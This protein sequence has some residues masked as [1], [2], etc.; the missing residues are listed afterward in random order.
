MANPAYEQSVD[1]SCPHDGWYNG[2]P[3]LMIINGTYADYRPR[4][5]GWVASG[6]MKASDL[7]L[8][9][10][11][12]SEI[13]LSEK[14]K[15]RN[16]VIEDTTPKPVKLRDGKIEMQAK[17]SDNGLRLAD[18]Q[19]QLRKPLR[20]KMAPGSIANRP[21][22]LALEAMS[23]SSRAMGAEAAPNGLGKTVPQFVPQASQ[24]PTTN[25][26]K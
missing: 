15:R 8:F 13:Q 22:P 3:K 2:N 11:Q 23:A 16:K 19:P 18:G 26:P 9:D 5:E 10:K 1:T 17:P 25:L 20:A 14:Q 12:W 4:L 21:D 7:A 24:V 6:K